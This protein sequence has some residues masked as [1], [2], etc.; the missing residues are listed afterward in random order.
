[1]ETPAQSFARPARRRRTRISKVTNAAA[2]LAEFDRGMEVYCLTFG[3]FSLMDAL[4]AL[5]DRIGPAHVAVATW[6]AAA[7]DLSRSAEMLHD[8][9]FLSMRFLVDCSFPQRQ[10]GY[11]A[12]LVDLFG[13]DAIR[14]TRTHAKFVVMT[15]DEW[16]VVIRT[17]MNLNENPRLENIEVTDDPEFAAFMLA[18]VDTVFAE[19][20]AAFVH[21]EPPALLAL[22]GIAPVS[23][24]RVGHGVR[25]GPRR[26]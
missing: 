19:E 13:V 18:I 17:S 4:L 26:G 10:P 1:M 6:T 25:T 2:A 14:T 21:K 16:N 11:A 7:A 3:Q 15:N 20:D 24:V 9:R 23:S 8:R 5:L 12:Q 22:P